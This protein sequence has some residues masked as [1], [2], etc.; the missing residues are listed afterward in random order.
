MREPTTE[1][2]LAACPE[3]IPSSTIPLKNKG[4]RPARHGHQ[5]N[6]WYSEQDRIKAATTYAMVGSAVEVERITSIPAAIVRK[7]KTMEWWPRIL[8]RIRQEH[9]DQLDVKL[10]KVIDDSVKLVQDRLEGGDYI[11]DTKRGEVVRKPMAGKEVAVITSIFVD[12]RNLLRGKPTSR[13]ERSSSEDRL[14]KLREEFERFTKA[15][16]ITPEKPDGEVIIENGDMYVESE[17]TSQ[18]ETLQGEDT[19]Q[20]EGMLKDA[21]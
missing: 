10:T 5:K 8:D 17:S 19:V 7:W 9:D 1:A 18:G 12:K 2:I 13:V 20:T 14:K 16:D 21:A 6:K 11:Y 4:G 3:E 15:R